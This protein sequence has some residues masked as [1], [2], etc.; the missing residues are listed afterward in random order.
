M[1]ERRTRRY[2]C[3]CPSG[4]ASD[5]A[6]ESLR[7]QT[8]LPNE[9]VTDTRPACS[10]IETD[11]LCGIQQRQLNSCVRSSSAFS[12]RRCSGSETVVRS[13]CRSARFVLVEMSPQSFPATTQRGTPDTAQSLTAQLDRAHANLS[14][15]RTADRSRWIECRM[16]DERLVCERRDGRRVVVGPERIETPSG[17]TTWNGPGDIQVRSVEPERW[18]VTRDGS[19]TEIELTPG[20]IVVT[21]PGVIRRTYEW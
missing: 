9:R 17:T 16:V 5:T 15:D 4:C 13:I 12:F 20:R 11:H 10:G 1:C 3:V 2:L 18:L 19:Q 7:W 21:E 6:S 8:H 14:S